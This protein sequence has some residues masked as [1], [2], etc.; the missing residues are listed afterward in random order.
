MSKRAKQGD[1]GGVYLR[2]VPFY[3]KLKLDFF[4]RKE[5]NGNPFLIHTSSS[6]SRDTEKSETN[7]AS[8]HVEDLPHTDAVVVCCCCLFLFFLT[9]IS[10]Q[11]GVRFPPPVSVCCMSVRSAGTPCKDIPDTPSEDNPVVISKVARLIQ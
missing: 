7:K 10:Y 9:L 5:L 2:H 4:L 6:H 3:T 11:R 8:L 1:K